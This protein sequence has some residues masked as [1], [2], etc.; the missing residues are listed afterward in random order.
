MVVVHG[1]TD[2]DI[3]IDFGIGIELRRQNLVRT[4]RHSKFNM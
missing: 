1:H 3:D 4:V 2:I